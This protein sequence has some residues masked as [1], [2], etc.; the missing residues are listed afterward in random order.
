MNEE[1]ATKSFDSG[2]VTNDHV[3]I[4]PALLEHPRYRIVEFL[5]R[6]GMSTVYKAEQLLFKRE[7]ALKV[8]SQELTRFPSVQQQFSC[9]LQA[10]GRLAP[11]HPNIVCGYDADKI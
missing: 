2:N 8:I 3:Q 7:V 1:N 11:A 4:P 9:E 5:G 6:G 10:L